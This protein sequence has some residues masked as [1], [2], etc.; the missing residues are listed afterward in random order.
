MLTGSFTNSNLIEEPVGILVCW[1]L[2]RGGRLQEV[3]LIN[4]NLIEEPVGILVGWSLTRGGLPLVVCFVCKLS[5]L[6]CFFRG[7]RIR[8]MCSCI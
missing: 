1:S 5:V 4:S 6:I 7:C 2:K 8:I 3:S